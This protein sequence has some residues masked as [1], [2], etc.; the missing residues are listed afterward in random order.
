M[1]MQ[2]VPETAAWNLSRR[3]DGAVIVRVESRKN[4]DRTL[5][6]AVFAFRAGDPQ[7]SYWDE[8]LRRRDHQS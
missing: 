3:D 1:S 5:P 4:T 7:Y 2:S 8:Q 6:D